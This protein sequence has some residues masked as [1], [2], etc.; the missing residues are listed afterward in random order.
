MS[1]CQDQLWRQFYRGGMGEIL[2]GD[3]NELVESLIFAI[4]V[5]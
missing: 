3:S 4:V 2:L 5:K 1:R